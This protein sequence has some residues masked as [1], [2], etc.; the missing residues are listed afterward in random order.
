MGEI[1]DVYVP[2]DP[3][4]NGEPWAEDGIVDNANDVQVEESINDGLPE[5]A[6]E[7]IP[8]PKPVDE[9]APEQVIQDENR[10]QMN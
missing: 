6:L 7:P 1:E 4:V 5:E 2:D 9:Q 8:V 10:H 3:Q